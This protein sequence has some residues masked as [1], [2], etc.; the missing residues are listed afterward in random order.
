MLCIYRI[1][2]SAQT[3]AIKPK[4]EHATKEKCLQQFLNIFDKQNTIIIADCVSD[5][6]YRKI[7]EMMAGF[8]QHIVRTQFRSGAFSFLAAV[9]IALQTALSDDTPVYLCEDD[10]L[11]KPNAKQLLLEGLD[12][13]DYCSA[14]DHPDKYMHDNITPCKVY[15]TP[16]THWRTTPSTTMTFAAKI[17]TLREDAKI[18]E[19]YCKT[20][21]PY[22]HE[23]FLALGTHGRKLVTCIPGASTHAEV[24]WLSPLV[25]WKLIS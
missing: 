6:T 24:A 13:A 19:E 11:H 4:L 10:Y 16:S 25:D 8:E 23:M 18:Y 17:R 2:D 15:L 9:D 12:V 22:D 1:S 7:A 5:E 20:G 14:Y 3:S 21:Y